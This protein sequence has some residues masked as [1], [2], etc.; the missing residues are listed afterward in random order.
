MARFPTPLA[1]PFS[2][3]IFLPPKPPSLPTSWTISPAAPLHVADFVDSAILS[4]ASPV[5]AMRS[6]E[7]SP[8]APDAKFLAAVLIDSAASANFLLVGSF[9][10]F[11]SV[12]NSSTFVSCAA[13][14]PTAELS[15]PIFANLARTPGYILPTATLAC[16]GLF[17][18]ATTFKNFVW[19]RSFFPAF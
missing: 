11:A 19:S 6:A 1:I 3:P 2:D 9:P 5:A 8:L 17:Q 13:P 15:E 18:P 4:G 16:P 12:L 14:E 10:P 7:K